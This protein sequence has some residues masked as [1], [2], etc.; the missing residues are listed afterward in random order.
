MEIVDSASTVMKPVTVLAGLALTAFVIDRLVTAFLFLLSYFWEQFDPTLFDGHERAEAD[1]IY[2]LVYF[3][4]AS[5]LALAAYHYIFR[6]GAV[7]AALDFQPNSVLDAV[8]AT[9]VLVGGADRIAALLKPPEG[10]KSSAPPPP[11]QVAGSVMLVTDAA[12]GE[13]KTGTWRTR[14]EEL[15]RK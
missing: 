4:L 9:L 11:L 5:I 3:S 1:R 8:V 10:E 12:S 13:Q 2:K 14:L 15:P 7:F 6:P